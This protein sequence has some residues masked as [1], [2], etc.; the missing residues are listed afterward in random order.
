MKKIS[1]AITSLLII[2]LSIIPQPEIET[3]S[4]LLFEGS[5]KII[6]LLMYAVL[7]FVW[8]KSKIFFSNQLIR[9]NWLFSGLLYCLGLGLILEILQYCTSFGR[10]LDFFDI[11]ANATGSL[12]VFIIFK[13]KNF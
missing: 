2:T 3:K 7:M 11:I 8:I 4:I 1:L 9:N 13:I 6:H 10:S 5:D 12:L